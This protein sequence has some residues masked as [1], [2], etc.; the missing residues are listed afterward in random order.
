[1]MKKSAKKL[2]KMYLRGKKMTNLTEDLGDCDYCSGGINFKKHKYWIK[3]NV[4]NSSEALTKGLLCENCVNAGLDTIDEFDFD[5]SEGD[6]EEQFRIFKEI[7]KVI[8]NKEVNKIK[9]TD[10]HKDVPK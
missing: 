7:I 8:R 2:R 5:V 6:E 4:T 10:A 3:K 1:M 9:N